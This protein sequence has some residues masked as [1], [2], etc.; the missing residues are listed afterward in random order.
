M[1][2]KDGKYVKGFINKY[3]NESFTTNKLPI[4][5]AQLKNLPNFFLF[6]FSF[7]FFFFFDIEISQL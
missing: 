4:A 3:K 5:G 7:F 2:L 1:A 6:F